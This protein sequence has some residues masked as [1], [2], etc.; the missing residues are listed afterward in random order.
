MKAAALQRSMQLI[1]MFSILKLP[2][3]TLNNS[4]AKVVNQNPLKKSRCCKIPSCE[5]KKKK[6]IKGRREF[7]PQREIKWERKYLD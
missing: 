2:R 7:S 3:W 4:I 1:R 5:E 6:A